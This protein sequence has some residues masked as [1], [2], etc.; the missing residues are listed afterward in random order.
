MH[1]SHPLTKFGIPA[2]WDII[3]RIAYMRVWYFNKWSR[4]TLCDS[5]VCSSSSAG[6][7]ISAHLE[8]W[9]WGTKNILTRI[10]KFY[11]ERGFSNQTN[12]N[13]NFVSEISNNFNSISRIIVRNE[14]EKY[15]SNNNCTAAKLFLETFIQIALLHYQIVHSNFYF[16]AD[17][18]FF[19][20]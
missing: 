9:L 8:R 14:V 19:I 10:F 15:L 1:A 5:P 18:H 6:V 2:T 7:S 16:N 11:A 12:T 17:I 3:A 20:K 4:Q 13:Q